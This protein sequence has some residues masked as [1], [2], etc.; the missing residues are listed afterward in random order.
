[1]QSILDTIGLLCLIGTLAVWA[2][3]INRKR[4]PK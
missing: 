2:F 3:I 4:A 1:M